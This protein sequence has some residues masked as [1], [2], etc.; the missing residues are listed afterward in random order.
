VFPGEGQLNSEAAGQIQRGN[1]ILASLRYCAKPQD[2][3]TLNI[4]SGIQEIE[5]YCAGTAFLRYDC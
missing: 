2:Y 5:F 3:S 1:F 4:Q